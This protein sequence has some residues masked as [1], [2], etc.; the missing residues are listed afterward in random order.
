M[1]FILEKINNK[2]SKKYFQ[3]KSFINMDLKRKNKNHNL[4]LNYSKI[5]NN[6][7]FSNSY[8]NL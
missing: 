2:I 4:S 5:K 7:S 1:L 8:S 3:D 6:K